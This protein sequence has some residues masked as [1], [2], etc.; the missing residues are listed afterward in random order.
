MS[1][2]AR[3]QRPAPDGEFGFEGRRRRVGRVNVR[4]RLG[5]DGERRG[6][7]RRRWRRQHRW[8]GGGSARSGEPK[9]LAGPEFGFEGG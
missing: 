6:R 9:G 8:W 3:K 1:A 5:S 7:E 2:S 4:R